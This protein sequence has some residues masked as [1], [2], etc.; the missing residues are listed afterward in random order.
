MVLL[1]PSTGAV[2][3]LASWPTFDP[4][5]F[6][7]ATDDE[8]RNRPVSDAYEPG[9]TFKMVTAAAALEEGLIDPDE[10][11]DCEMGGITLAGVRISDHKAFGML[12][13]RE[14]IAKS[15]NVGTIKTSLRLSN[16]S[17]YDAIRAFGFGRTSG[18]DLPGESPGLLMPVARWPALAK[19]Y[20]SF[21][22]GISITPLQLAL[23]LRRGSQRRPPARAVSGASDRAAEPA[24]RSTTPS[25]WS[26]AVRSPRRT[27]TVVAELLAGVTL[28]GGTGKAAVV[29]GYPVAG[30]TGTAQKAEPGKGYLRERVHRQLRRLRADGA[31]GDRRGRG[32]R[33]SARPVY[34]GG[35]V[36]APVFAA[37]AQQALLYLNVP[38]QR[39][40]PERWPGEP[41]PPS[42][43]RARRSP[44][45]PLAAAE[46][47]KPGS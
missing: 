39:D 25:P 5:R 19:A 4:N 41:E 37:I 12:T 27:L 45:N 28:E 46:R 13:F 24:P 22:Q 11:L 9:S 38:P 20:I 35:E 16:A 17:F 10:L 8:R 26:A 1:D 30:K 23:R 43:E 2:L 3:A 31:S 29:P 7:A 14:V 34:H 42:E 21:G 33:R 40:R 18:L 6:A 36:A 15:S 47:R 32:H 44:E